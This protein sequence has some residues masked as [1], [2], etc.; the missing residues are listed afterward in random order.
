VKIA[1]ANRTPGSAL[2]VCR[3]SYPKTA[4]TFREALSPNRRR[5]PNPGQS[6]G[7]NTL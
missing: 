6:P 4:G 3:A 1:H 5:A 2:F 7:V